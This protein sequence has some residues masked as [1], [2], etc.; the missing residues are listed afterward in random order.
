[1]SVQVH[2][3]LPDNLWEQLSGEAKVMRRALAE[4]IRYQLE[5]RAA[6]T[7][8]LAEVR[9]TFTPIAGLGGVIADT[10]GELREA[11]GAGQEALSPSAWGVMV[12]TLILLRSI[13]AP[14]KMKPAQTLVEMAGLPVFNAGGA[15]HG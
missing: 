13:A 4:H 8:E 6:Y 5:E 11:A 9:A 1:M 10:L 2:L 14:A 12:E 3:R 15:Q 7:R